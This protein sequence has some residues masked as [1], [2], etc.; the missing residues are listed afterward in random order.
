MEFAVHYHPVLPSGPPHTYTHTH[1][2]ASLH[3][4]Q[5]CVAQIQIVTEK[6][7][8]PTPG[9]CTVLS[10]VPVWTLPNDKKKHLD[11]QTCES[12]FGQTW[13]VAI[14]NFLLCSFPLAPFL[15][16][17]MLTS[18]EFLVFFQWQGSPPHVFFKRVGV[19]YWQG[20]SLPIRPYMHLCLPL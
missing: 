4:L 8:D 20:F 6:K 18:G 14:W 19:H 9:W 17:C 10:S 3:F 5:T 11:L 2:K 16:A 1:F 7:N 12:L 13:S 15:G